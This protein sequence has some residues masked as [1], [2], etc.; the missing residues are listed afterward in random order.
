M[1][2]HPFALFVACVSALVAT[3]SVA[4]SREFNRNFGSFCPPGA[5]MI[6]NGSSGYCMCPDGS[7]AYGNVPCGGGSYQ[8]PE[9]QGTYCR[10]GGMCPPGSYCASKPGKCIPEGDVD[11]G[12]YACKQGAKC[13]SGGC[14]WED[15]EDCGDGSSCPAGQ[16]CWRAPRDV[17]AYDIRRGARKCVTSEQKASLEALLKE[18]AREEREAKER[19]VA[20]KKRKAEEEKRAAEQ[21]RIDA[22][23][24]SIQ[25]DE[26]ALR[27]EASKRRM[28][29]LTRQAQSEAN[30]K[31]ARPANWAQQQLEALA[32]G[33]GSQHSPDAST[34]T[35]V[36]PSVNNPNSLVVLKPQ[37]QERRAIVTGDKP[38]TTHPTQAI[39]S[40]FTGPGLDKRGCPPPVGAEAQAEAAAR[41]MQRDEEFRRAEEERRE[42]ERA[43]AEESR[44]KANAEA[45]K[46]EAEMREKRYKDV[47]NV[48][49]QGC[50]LNP[51]GRTRCLV[52][53]QRGVWCT[54]CTTQ[55]NCTKGLLGKLT[56]TCGPSW[57][58]CETR[59][60]DL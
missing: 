25:K 10:G 33:D 4:I 59:C 54:V 42:K 38:P 47:V 56:P 55:R 20:E 17:P 50:G 23:R 51:S 35:P 11:C 29:E 3:F 21:K 13:S 41:Q 34:R 18:M 37:L 45:A 22:N 8:Q 1:R 9:P 58:N 26:H 53:G 6:W 40:T 48:R 14:I 39:C 60:H 7:M 43:A 49:K 44:R 52:L 32:R 15:E 28:E 27:L 30:G 2:A 12:N 5:Q 16:S 46:K 24:A 31:T 57:E 19:A 36:S